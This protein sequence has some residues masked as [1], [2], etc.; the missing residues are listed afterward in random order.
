M[1]EG[2]AS[3]AVTSA[4]LAAVLQEIDEKYSKFF[5]ALSKQ[6]GG[7]RPEVEARE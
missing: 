7:S 4:E 3:G 5:D 2:G 6:G 1:A